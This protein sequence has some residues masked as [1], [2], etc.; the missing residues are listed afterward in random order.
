MNQPSFNNSFL[1]QVVPAI[2]NDVGQMAYIHKLLNELNT[3]YDSNS[4]TINE[5]FPS[6]LTESMEWEF[7]ND[8]RNIG[9]WV[10]AEF[11][12]H[13]EG[14]TAEAHI[15]NTASMCEALGAFLHFIMLERFFIHSECINLRAYRVFTVVDALISNVIAPKQ[16]DKRQALEFKNSY[17]RYKLKYKGEI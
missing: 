10:F 14:I 9:I 4:K 1:K 11:E 13:R 16:F 15:D 8:I 7:M 6:D 3:F 17:I 2:A 5:A 12:K